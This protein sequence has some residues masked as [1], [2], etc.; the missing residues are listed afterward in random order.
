MQFTDRFIMLV[1]CMFYPN[2]QYLTVLLANKSLYFHY[3]KYKVQF[4]IFAAF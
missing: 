2:N 4:F 3:I 1:G